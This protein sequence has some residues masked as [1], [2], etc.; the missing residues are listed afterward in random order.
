M[1][2]DYVEQ[3]LGEDVC[4]IDSGDVLKYPAE[5]IQRY[6][7]RVGFKYN[8]GLLEWKKGIPESWELHESLVAT[9]DEY[10]WFENVSNSTGWGKGIKP[11]RQIE[12]ELPQSVR[13]LI[14]EAVPYYEKL[15][16]HVKRI[17]RSG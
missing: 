9:E 2:L 6:C 14:E 16:K 11:S 17:I 15:M 7:G 12:D 1:T 8:D 3:S 13:D 4:I 5:M 10:N